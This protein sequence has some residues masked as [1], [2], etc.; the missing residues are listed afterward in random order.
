MSPL[1]DELART[2]N[3]YCDE[4]CHLEHDGQPIMVLGAIWCPTEKSREIAIRIREIKAK[5][6]LPR[7]YEV[8]WERV[9]PGKLQFYLDIIDYFFDDARLNFRAYIAAKQGLK[10]KDFGQDHDTW[11]FKMYFYMLAL[12]LHPE[13]RYRIYLDIKD[14]RSASKVATL[15]NVLCNNI[16]DFEHSIIERV[17]TV[18]SREVEQIQLAD[19]MIG[20]ISYANRDLKTSHAKLSVIDRMKERSGH[21]LTTNTLMRAEKLNLFH[22][23]PR[24]VKNA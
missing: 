6:S 18:N 17:Q 21:R 5:H 8:K 16:F 13:R 9:S 7:D 2:F 20:A 10:H 23:S 22:W 15:H 12:I 14:S 3:V 24:E 19:L 1:A 11:Y 4:S